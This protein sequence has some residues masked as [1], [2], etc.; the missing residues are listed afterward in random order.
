MYPIPSIMN[1]QQPCIS[2]NI[3]N[4]QQPHHQPDHPDH[5]NPNTTYFHQIHNNQPRMKVPIA[6]W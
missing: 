1:R 6:K 5:H 3:I 2:I 4:R